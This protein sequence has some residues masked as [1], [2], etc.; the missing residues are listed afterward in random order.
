MIFPAGDT[1]IIT[2]NTKEIPKNK[3]KGITAI[4]KCL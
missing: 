4:V 3:V 2:V 1:S